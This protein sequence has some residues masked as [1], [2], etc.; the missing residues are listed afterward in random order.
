MLEI[1]AV[2]TKIAMSTLLTD[3]FS[4]YVST[5]LSSYFVCSKSIFFYSYSNLLQMYNTIKAYS[6]WFCKT[7]CGL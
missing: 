2:F 3:Q 5:T 1:K 4:N 6:A 7:H